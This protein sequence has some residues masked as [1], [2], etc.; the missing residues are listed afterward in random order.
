MESL[1]T[2]ETEVK[3]KF[4]QLIIGA[5]GSGKTTYIK[6][7]KEFYSQCGRKTLSINLDPANDNKTSSFDI[8]IRNLINLEEV[9]KKLKLGPN[10]SFLYCINFLNDN[11]S[12]LEEQINQEKYKDYYYYLID[13]PGQIEIFT[14]SP[15]FK[16]ICDYMTNEKKLNIKLCCVNLIECINMCDMPKYIFSIFSVLNS[17]INLALPQVNFISKCDL[18]KELKATHQF[19]LPLEF[20]KNPNDETQLKYYFEDLKMNKKFKN[21]NEKIAEFIADYGLVGFTLLDLSNTRHLNRAAYL[22]D[23]ANGYIYMKELIDNENLDSQMILGQNDFEN[24]DIID[25]EYEV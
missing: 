2:L 20:Y 6:S 10:G 21:L 12:W 3:Q 25:E 5:P 16:N 14:I 19:E 4:G 17:M 13:T 8:D 1:E 11:I 22:I 15:E 9:E 7:M 23:K 24:E 18:I